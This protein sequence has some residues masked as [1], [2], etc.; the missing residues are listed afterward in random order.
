MA[1]THYPVEFKLRV[2][3][4]AAEVGNASEVAR[5]YEIHPTMVSRWLRAYRRDGENAFDR[6]NGSPKQRNGGGKADSTRIRE[7]ENEN[8]RLKQLIGEK[9]LEIAI[10][11]DLLKK[12]N[13]RLLKN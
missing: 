9:E 5:R 4:E 13:R 2:V 6:T 8:D 1:R 3:R 7:I 11:R 10:L 12:G